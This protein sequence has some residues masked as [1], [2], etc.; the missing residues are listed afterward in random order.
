MGDIMKFN[1]KMELE[2]SAIS[3]NEGFARVAVASFISQ[4]NPTLAEITEVKTA[5]SEA[6]TN[7]I[8]HG[9][10]MNSEKRVKIVC[11]IED[12]NA[13]ITV[14]DVG[15]GIENIELAR[16]ALYTTKPDM[17]R[18]GMG[19]TIMEE[20]MDDIEVISN[21]GEGTKIVMRKRFS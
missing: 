6:V 19:F 12:R 11:T 10:E 5:V 20:F 21:V 7:A 8:I 18:S 16:E 9:Y 3:A 15:C 14:Q 4:I 1:N 17:E 2:F 13:E